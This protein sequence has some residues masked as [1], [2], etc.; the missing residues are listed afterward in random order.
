MGG[1]ELEADHGGS[2]RVHVF[3]PLSIPLILDA[4]WCV[5]EALLAATI[6]VA[7][8]L[9]QAIERIRSANARTIQAAVT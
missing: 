5:I 6:L 9:R 3:F 1:A 2:L 7:L 8:V 4:S